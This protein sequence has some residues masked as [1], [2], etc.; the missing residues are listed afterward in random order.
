VGRAAINTIG[1]AREQKQNEQR[2][3]QAANCSN[4]SVALTKADVDLPRPT[5]TKVNERCDHSMR[6]AAYGTI[7]KGVFDRCAA[8]SRIAL[9]ASRRKCF[10][11]FDHD[12]TTSAVYCHNALKVTRTLINLARLRATVT[13]GSAMI[14]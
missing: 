2:T 4:S 7:N 13:A 8:R 10:A 1:E 12:R 11:S 5:G 3:S 9:D 14:Y 6:L